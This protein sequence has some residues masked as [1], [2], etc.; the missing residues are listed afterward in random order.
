MNGCMK[1]NFL[2]TIS[3]ELPTLPGIYFSKCLQDFIDELLSKKV[4]KHVKNQFPVKEILA[5]S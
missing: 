5:I 2:F 4:E 3:E 1:Y